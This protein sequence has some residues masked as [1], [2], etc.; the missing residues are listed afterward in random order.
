MDIVILGNIRDL[1]DHLNSTNMVITLIIGQATD[2][3]EV[4]VMPRIQ[5]MCT[6]MKLRNV[7]LVIGQSLCQ[8]MK[9]SNSMLWNYTLML[10]Y[11][12]CV[13]YYILKSVNLNFSEIYF[14]YFGM[15]AGCVFEL[16]E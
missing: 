4:T 9:S 11:L 13:K 3:E 12:L 10:S 8:E 1:E 16:W 14:F 15:K 2:Q 6:G 7:I 5:K